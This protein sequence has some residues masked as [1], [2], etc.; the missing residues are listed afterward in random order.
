ME[1]L[2]TVAQN[3]IDKARHLLQTGIDVNCPVLWN[4]KNTYSPV[5]PPDIASR[6]DLLAKL[7]SDQEYH[8]RPLNIAVLGGHAEMVRLLLS[9]GADINIK[10]GRGRTA[11]ICAIHGL[12]MDASDINT[13]NLHLISQTHNTHLLIM[14]KILLRHPNLYVSTLNS[15]QYEI[16]GITPLCLASY[17][18]KSE[19]I[20]LLLEDGR[21]DVDGT[22]S[23]NASALMYAARDGNLPIV[24]MLL[25]YDASPDIT[26][27]H[28]WSAIQY[29]ENNSEIVQLCEETLRRKRPDISMIHAPVNPIARYPVS[30]TNL[31]TLI[32]SLPNY[33][34][35]L[36]HL[37]FDTL[38]DIDLMDPITAPIVHIVQMSFLH[39]IKSHD[40]VSL[41]TLL[42]WSPP[43][44][45]DCNRST[46]ALLI[47]YHD[48]KTGLT[49]IHHAMRAKPLPSLDTLT[50]L[51]QA[52]ADIN[53]QTCYGR[54]ALHHL[55]RIGMDQDGKSWGI[56]KKSTKL[57]P[58]A[59]QAGVQQ[60]PRLRAN[61]SS[62]LQP[63]MP[64][65]FEEGNQ[66]PSAVSEHP[67]ATS[68]TSAS[69]F[70]HRLSTFSAVSSRSAGSD[71]TP[72]SSMVDV[73]QDP[74]TQTILAAPTIPAHLG[75]CA[76]LLIQLGALVNIADPT[77]NTPLHFAAEFGAVSEV[78]EVL[79]MEGNAD[80]HLKNKKQQTPLD[81]CKTDEIRT[82]ML[83]LEKERKT[84]HRT[85]STG[86]SGS[87]NTNNGSIRPFDT[88]SNYRHSLTRSMSKSTTQSTSTHGNKGTT[89]HH[90]H[91]RTK[92]PT[93]VIIPTSASEVA[94][95]DRTKEMKKKDDVLNQIDMDFDHIL[96]AF[97]N[98]HTT[99]TYSIGK[100][101]AYITKTVLESREGNNMVIPS[102]IRS[103][104]EWILKRT[105]VQ[106]RYDLRDAHDNFDQ[107][108][109]RAERMMLLYREKL[110]QVEQTHQAD[111][112]LLELQQDKVE[113]LYDVFERIEDRFCQLEE[114]Q[115]EL[116]GQ[117]EH[118]RR[119]A[120]RQ[121][122]WLEQNDNGVKHDEAMYPI[123]LDNMMQS[124]TILSIIPATCDPILYSREDRSRL[125][126]DLD[127][128]IQK[129]LQQIPSSPRLANLRAT[130]EEK[131]QHVESVLANPPPRASLEDKKDTNTSVATTM[132]P[133]SKPAADWQRQ[134]LTASLYSVSL[135]PTPKRDPRSLNE[136][137]L[138]F[139]I[140]SANLSE[141]QKDMDDLNTQSSHVMESKK[142]MY[143]VCLA[144]ERELETLEKSQ[145]QQQQHQ[146]R[147]SS[148]ANSTA[149]VPLD[150][151]PTIVRG[152]L[153]Q[154]MRCAQ[155]LFDRQTLLDQEAA[156]LKTEYANI[157][158]QLD[159]IKE[160]LR[161]VRPP[162]L[163]QGLL[164]RLD[165][166]DGPTVHV[167]TDWQEDE[168]LVA[169]FREDPFDLH[170][171][172]L[173]EESDSTFSSSSSSLSSLGNN[174]NAQKGS[175]NTNSS[176][177]SNSTTATTQMR[178]VF[179]TPLAIQCLISRLDASLYSLKVLAAYHLRRSRQLLLEVQ[180][181]LT[182]ASEDV[183]DSCD[184]MT[185][186]YG[187][188]AEIAQRVR[189][190][191]D[192]METV[193]R[194]RKE[195][196]VEVWEVVD[197]VSVGIDTSTVI[198]QHQHEIP[199]SATYQQQVDTARLPTTVMSSS[200]SFSPSDRQHQRH[201]GSATSTEI[202]D[203]QDQQ[204]LI[205]RGLER[206]QLFHEHLQ[207]DI[208]ALKN[209]QAEIDQRIRYATD[210]LIEPQ[211]D[212]L[213]GQDDGSLLSISD[214]LVA[215]MDGI[216]LH[217]LGLHL[218][219]NKKPGTTKIRSNNRNRKPTL[220][221]QN[222]S[223]VNPPSS[224]SSS[225]STTTTTND[226][227]LIRLSTVS[228]RSSRTASTMPTSAAN[229][230]RIS[231]AQS[232]RIPTN[233][234]RT[235]VMSTSSLSSLSSYQQERMLSRA[236][237]LSQALGRDRT[238]AQHHS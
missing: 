151:T 148:I 95:I 17:L 5:I 171:V 135:K 170:R 83:A 85:Q 234:K 231:L 238:S 227:R 144:L 64:T 58:A 201:Q 43:I 57:A 194:H 60:L 132:T 108:E 82:F 53:A 115:D 70:A 208:E 157:E 7:Q 91:S 19:M 52:G 129:V 3:N 106:L 37:E 187:N 180:V 118:W 61:S 177:N 12:D 81:I 41:Q 2:I 199:S 71:T 195:E 15:P 49:A 10:D 4:A 26:D 133:Y 217:N 97:F 117:L 102:S 228:A 32:S 119:L 176:S 198:Q 24:Q 89:Q 215:L 31:S 224:L 72:R 90:Q 35:S 173:A 100:A 103:E 33:Q 84:A 139:D 80:L 179:K 226:P 16:K 225:S 28:G 59:S 223:A 101:L 159:D 197:D 34:S 182:Q 145:Q 163:L 109:Q 186:L 88:A 232:M 138:S 206:F 42:L 67:S 161:Q 154:V 140:L 184:Q 25:S 112:E 218:D 98:Y 183:E 18:G 104:E 214:S 172:D 165:T 210:S 147:T 39:S 124:L 149:I 120:L 222:S 181:C 142:R 14:K 54:T 92:S 77:G 175:S 9:A 63:T 190:F 162:L 79:I 99:F 212:R 105:V 168:K 158:H 166:E 29:A 20:E 75:L 74:I 128:I 30:Y 1:F 220:P 221:I 188:A 94:A 78:L 155:T 13:S 126:R 127:Q 23:K 65:H 69:S 38:Q 68:P 200:S 143:D 169:T 235:S 229:N 146:K 167:E 189:S 116:I 237:T 193:I 8:T 62:S 178:N 76:S 153:D 11:L 121:L 87:T 196:I 209:D 131:W 111:C 134:L 216:C 174:E 207:D 93:S 51:Y 48:T 110:T 22:D 219:E 27:S 55:A 46:G 164:E 86:S 141:I 113:K 211:V 40:H 6:P 185:V 73:L 204:Q 150:R 233:R 152:E 203:E 236:S 136:L 191:K 47:N 160:A 122:R 192:E 21:V 130:L 66:T 50:M 123:C 36:S 56:Q 213:V 137:E 114:D 107:T 156:T 125:S 202:D 44:K 45:R 230:R 205:I 96:N